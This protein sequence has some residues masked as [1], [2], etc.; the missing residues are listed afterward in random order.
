MSY[1]PFFTLK[2][3]KTSNIASFSSTTDETYIL[4]IANDV[5][6]ILENGETV[7]NSGEHAAVIGANVI[8]DT[9]DNHEAFISLR[10][11]NINAV[12]AKFNSQ[13]I[14]FKVDTLFDNDIIP[15]SSN[16]TS[17][18]G[19]ENNR[20]G[21]IYGSNIIAN[22]S[23]LKN[24]NLNDK[25]T[26]DLNETSENRYYKQSY[27]NNDLNTRL[28]NIYNND[29]ITLDNI[30][31]G[32]INKTIKNNY[33]EGTL[34]VD[35][36]I[37][38][39]YNPDSQG[40]HIKYNI[41]VTNTDQ[42]HEGSTN[43]YFTDNRVSNIVI[44]Q[45]EVIK[46]YVDNRLDN[47]IINTDDITSNNEY[48]NNSN[49]ELANSNLHIINNLN[50][51]YTDSIAT[52]LNSDLIK[53]KTDTQFGFNYFKSDLI[54]TSNIIVNNVNDANTLSLSNISN[55]EIA[56]INEV[57]IITSSNLKFETTVDTLHNYIDT[58]IPII[59][60]LLSQYNFNSIVNSNEIIN[61][62]NLNI[63]NSSNYTSNLNIYTSNLID[64]TS[65]NLFNYSC[66]LDLDTSN[67][68]DITSNNLFND[69]YNLDLDTSNLIDITSNN[70][71]NY[72]SNLNVNISN[73]L[74]ENE[75]Y[76]L[77]TSNH[78][79]NLDTNISNYLF[80]N[81]LDILQTSNNIGTLDIN[82]SNYFINNEAEIVRSSNLTSNLNV[83]ISNYLFKN[84]LDIL[85]TSN[86]IGTLD[87][88]ISNYLIENEAE[89]IRS[90]NLITNLNV[91]ISNYLIENELDILQTS[92]HIGNL[93]TNISNYFINNE[94]EIVRSSNLISNLDVNISNYFIN[95][96]AEIIRSSNLITNLNVNIS[97][98]LIENEAE[99][100]RT[101][102]YIDITS[103]YLYIYTNS[104]D[105]DT[106]NYIYDTS[107]YLEN[108]INDID[109]KITI[110]YKTKINTIGNNFDLIITNLN[111]NFSNYIEYNSNYI[112]KYSC[113]LDLDTSN[114]I[115]ITTNHLFNIID[116]IEYDVNTKLTLIEAINDQTTSIVTQLNIQNLSII[117]NVE[118]TSNHIGN[119]D[120]N[121]SNYLFKNE[122]DILQTSNHIGNLD[123]NISNYLFENE[124]DIL[125]TSNHIGNLD[126]NI[127]NYLFKNELDILQTSNHIGN[128]DTNISNYLFKNELDILQTSN[129]IN[130]LDIK[131][132]HIINDEN[133]LVEF[134]L[135]SSN[136]NISNYINNIESKTSNIEIYSDGNIK[137]NSDLTIDGTLYVNNIDIDGETTIINT[138][139]YQTENLEIINNQGDGPSLKIDHKNQNNNIFE[140]SNLEH[141]III[142]NTGK[143]GINKTP[144]ID[145]DI[146]GSV[147]IDNNLIVNNIAKL[148]N[149][150]IHGDIIPLADDYSIG[151][152]EK[153]WKS[154]YL[155]NTIHLGNL[156]ISTET[157]D[158]TLKTIDNNN[159]G[160][161]VS[162]L[163]VFNDD[164]YRTALTFDG[165]NLEFQG[166]DK[167]GNIINT[168]QKIKGDLSVD[169]ILTLGGG[170]VIHGDLDINNNIIFNGNINNITKTELN[171]LDGTTKNIETNF[172]VTS[173][174]I[175]NLDTNI[176]NYLFKNELDILQTSNHIGNLDANISNYLIEN[177][178]EII[179]SSNL[180][181]NLNVNISNYLF[182]NELDILQTSNHI[183][184]LDT[185]ISNY[186]FK[187]ELDILQTSNHI[188]NLDTNIS[189]YLFKNE[190]DILQT[191]N[192]IGNLD[193]NISNYL[194][195]NEAEI[196]R[197][198]NLTSNLN[199]NISNYL[200]E[201][202]AEI[203]RSS[204]LTS[205]LNVNISNYLFKNE[206]DILQTSNYINDLDIKLLNIINNENELVEFKLLSSNN[207]IS[208]YINNIESKTSNIEVLTNGNIKLN[209]D[210]TIDGTLYV[211]NIDIDGETTIINTNTYQTENLE[212]INNQGDGPSLKIDH[213]NQNNNIIELVNNTNTFIIDKNAN[214]GIN[215]VPTVELDIEGNIKFNG[216]INNISA[217]ELN[218]LDGT[219]KNIETNFTV[220]SNHIGNLDI[221][222]SNYLFK[223]EL[224]IL[225][226]SNNIGNLD[227]NLSNY[228]INNEL[229]ILQT[230]NHIGSLDANISNYLF[231]NELDILQTSNHINDL[232]I[233]LLHIINDENELV[234]FKL[235][236][237][238]NNISN[239]INN[240]ESKTSNIESKTSNIEVLTN[241]N[242]KLN[243]DLTIGGTLYVNNI[244]IDGE[245]TII[246]TNTYQTENLEIINNQGDGPSLKIDHKN[247]NNN[248]IELVNNTDTFII[249]KNANVGI[250]KVPTVE[251]DIEGS[252]KFNGNI[253]NISANVLDYLN[254]TESS[255]QDQLNILKN[256]SNINNIRI[257]DLEY[258]SNINSNT[259]VLL[260][261]F[262]NITSNN[263]VDHDNRI[264]SIEEYNN[265][266]NLE[267]LINN[268]VITN[269]I[270]SIIN[271]GN[272]LSWDNINNKLINDIIQYT[273]D[274]VNTILTTNGYLTIDNIP[275]D[276]S[277]LH[278]VD[279]AL[280]VIDSNIISY[281]NEGVNIKI[282]EVNGIKQ[283]NVGEKQDINYITNSVIFNFTYATQTFHIPNDVNEVV[284]YL[285]GAG[286]GGGGYINGGCGGSGGFTSGIIDVS[287]ISKLYIHVGG[288]GE[289]NMYSSYAEAGYQYGGIGGTGSGA[290][291]GKSGIY[292]SSFSNGNEI[293]IAGGGG[294]GGGTNITNKYCN[295]GGG[296]GIEGR[297]GSII[298]HIIPIENTF[299]NAI[300]RGGKY[301]RGGIGGIS[302]INGNNGIRGEGGDA[303]YI[304]GILFSQGGGGAGYWGGG[305]GG[306]DN[307]F[308]IGSGGGGS[309]YIND[310]YVKN[311]ILL[312]ANTVITGD[313]PIN[314]PKSEN[315]YYI[316]GIGKGGINYGGNGGDGLIIL[317]YK[318]ENTSATVTE[319]LN[320]RIPFND[321]SIPN[322]NNIN[323]ISGFLKFENDKWLVTDELDERI[324]FLEKKTLESLDLIDTINII[325]NIDFIQIEN[326]L[327]DIDDIN[328][329]NS[330][331]VDEISAHNSN[332]TKDLNTNINFLNNDIITN[333]LLQDIDN[334]NISNYINNIEFKTSN[335]EVL[336]NGNIKLN[337]D[338]TIDGTLYVNNIDIDGETTII[339]TNTYQTENLEI[340]NN[341]G[342]GP[343][344]KIDHKNENNNIIELVNNTDTFI[345]DKNANVGINKVP[346][347]ELDIEGSIK[348]NGNINNISS[349]E[350]N[351]LAGTTK[352]IETNFAVTSNHIGNLDT[353]ISNYLFKNELYIL[354]T[355]NHITNL[356]TNLSNYL[357][358]NELDI[359]QT[360]NHIGI[361]DA[362]ISNYLF[363]NELYILQT[364]NHIGSLDA[365]ISNYLI[366]NELDILQT[367]NHIGSLDANISNYLI[368]NELYIL[369]TS[370]HIGNL[371][372][373]IS[374]YLIKN[375][376]DILQT[377]NR[378][379][380]LDTNI[381]NYLIL[382]ELDIL[383]TSN[384][385][386][387]LDTNISNYL[388]LNELD[389][390]RTSNHIGNLDTNI[391]NY[392]VE[393]EIDIKRTSNHIGYLD[394]KIEDLELSNKD[395]SNYIDNISNILSTFIT[396]NTLND[397]TRSNIFVN[398]NIIITTYVNN[399]AGDIIDLIQFNNDN[400]INYI[401]NIDIKV[402]T[403]IDST[404]NNLI[405][406][407][408][409]GSFGGDENNVS[410]Y[411][412]YT[413][414][415]I[416]EYINISSNNQNIRLDTLEENLED[417]LNSN[418]S[419][420]NLIDL[421]IIN[422]NLDSVS[423]GLKNQFIVNNEYDYSLRVKGTLNADNTILNNN[424][425]I[426]NSS[427]YNSGCV[428]IV[429]YGINHAI[430]IEQIGDGDILKVENN[431]IDILKI[432]SN[433]YIGNKNDI[434]YNID[435]DGYI[436]AT[437]LRGDG[438]MINNINLSD[439][440][441]AHLVEGSN[442]YYT[443]ERLY[444]FYQNSNLL[445]SNA[446]FT[447]ILENVQEIKHVMGLHQ[448]DRVEQGTS[449][450][451]IVNNIYNDDLIV[452]GHITA[453]SINILEL[454]TEYYTDLYYSNLFINPFHDERDTFANISNILRNVIIDEPTIGNN[455]NL[456]NRITDII[457][458][459]M[460]N[461]M[462]Q[463]NKIFNDRINNLTLDD[464][465]QG[466]I[467]KY[468]ISNIF[469]ENL[470]VNGNIITKLIDINIEDELFENYSNIY[471]HGLSN[472]IAGNSEYLENRIDSIVDNNMSNYY[473]LIDLHVDNKIKT[474][475]LDN[476]IQGDINKFIIK[477]IYNDDLIVNGEITTKNVD[478]ALDNNLST[479][480][481]NL[482]INEIIN[483]NIAESEYLSTRIT[484]GVNNNISNY[485]VTFNNELDNIN[486]NISNYIIK[487][488]NE[489]L[490]RIDNLTLDN[491]YQGAKNKYIVNDIYNNNL[492]VNGN[493]ITKLIDINIENE[494]FENYSNIY[495]ETLLNSNVDTNDTS[496][497]LY[498]NYIKLSKHVTN[499]TT[500]INNNINDI[501]NIITQYHPDE[502]SSNVQIQEI[503]SLNTK[504]DNL[505]NK[506]S[507]IE[508]ILLN[509]G[510]DITEL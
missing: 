164:G 193:I 71:F 357:I 397:I 369:Q 99:I 61:Y 350:L 287:N 24:V 176:S 272:G 465:Q 69:L 171:Y 431:Y 271:N 501:Y 441:T 340:I 220:T 14:L 351:Y 292:I 146:N 444:D 238:N 75:L 17:N 202:E 84:E 152:I 192:H 157:G 206:L 264:K 276:T 10:N 469:N 112:T 464:I 39:N 133:E 482:Y 310:I 131:L 325:S 191:S 27:F 461:Y 453:K 105:S 286:G 395:T 261:N 13:N 497:T 59:N 312:S 12:V 468:I 417:L 496:I 335:I 356:D 246:N 140:A 378:I 457:D 363:K 96:E 118:N 160:I 43:L 134:K 52:A 394:S 54:H 339:N 115:D 326:V 462:D 372:T 2:G 89:I 227:T 122:L 506:Y 236:S 342:D 329:N 226:T 81:E 476:I 400:T 283:L 375:E 500:L 204:N 455:S 22:G 63:I 49:Y 266:I 94:V 430:K 374:N 280:K 487:I 88:N 180:T 50:L 5:N 383:Q 159:A 415:E 442:L 336:T 224:Y 309:G 219:T 305:S 113:N 491:I 1:N 382:N 291:G 253:N 420:S 74:I 439:K 35:D 231:K 239:Y 40:F 459:G 352:H 284:A 391:S 330:N 460:L 4:L 360:S 144:T 478:I 189:N 499:Q 306:L 265:T 449:N 91:N 120:T 85:Q 474:I 198:S 128:L 488:N 302:D 33:Y 162:E 384:R 117:T 412:L 446:Q 93:D 473:S 95:N 173:N 399:T 494:L 60:S 125:Q 129:H 404:S 215:K 466:N 242:I 186:L 142:D 333:K 194:I 65:N 44:N 126:T 237:S 257:N 155:D 259:I 445:L 165:N 102:N 62:I 318:I 15:S 55:F 234:E 98:Y 80:K 211:N 205:N 213:K 90:S 199:V 409:N 177:E 313:I 353:N 410:N 230:S 448:L 427:I 136:N 106:S 483:H 381:S 148:S 76:I 321:L 243:S 221:N 138:N 405:E 47:I 141:F 161:N 480:Y 269:T 110:D 509:L 251:L 11:D 278:I 268:E 413:S 245:T 505:T 293:L 380:N 182:K 23:F 493:I 29:L 388:I 109:N 77:Q 73:Y 396:S 364:S 203:I 450:K 240:I 258:N 492:V 21:N 472:A 277:T 260:E 127:S 147:L 398:S 297:N 332:Y 437:N 170:Y 241:G 440:S 119:L 307:T 218:Y 361:L 168:T 432:T 178:E 301:N 275:L 244:D 315:E 87:I 132:L 188:G 416:I 377:S 114:Y 463:I 346:T 467:N 341:Q 479:L 26:N 53:L 92:N 403:S 288:G 78:I 7:T 294:G 70:L 121:I 149:I 36:I 64:I 484:D 209:S 408:N 282:N 458:Y 319:N 379:G 424:A 57:D 34:V 428:N 421:D 175:G 423:Q 130:D 56:I 414:N 502:M 503:N 371:D 300:G 317:I 270:P 426:V 137:L 475:S 296:G 343:S 334:H 107:N 311:S 103:N 456:E 486:N 139:T 406:Y 299:T 255:I 195:E 67:L 435:I 210:L 254:G 3:G 252:I 200:I 197:S 422:I 267:Q 298:E 370:N 419:I 304:N 490:N 349:T 163:N 322:N 385:I 248:I 348:F 337:S 222:I 367:S 436:N 504:L 290:G 447:E 233:K 32:T 46:N 452:L 324:N 389:I 262:S 16:I 181:S 232:D 225:Q 6:Q 30:Q 196:I 86:H 250:N 355:S 58:E 235:L 174:H 101:S 345:I 407:I 485:T 402:E 8:D 344:L 256:S 354:Q 285:W 214:V 154:I 470:I 143:L 328:R 289:G 124:L 434:T 229:D 82:I 83:N 387:N 25:T 68:I 320:Y 208:N 104:L 386:R 508:N 185:N 19:S 392:L 228:L 20:W 279:G 28:L 9:S 51:I 201:N 263:I 179:R 217:T 187:N 314:P 108:Y 481:S 438:S 116:T 495:N 411:V 338:L 273:D 249:D 167:N 471:N 376:L 41:N 72:S 365:N 366:N 362:N 358:N 507:K 145:L 38:N 66:N 510:Y 158:M 216:N 166:Y 295:G 207:N 281:E 169:G 303:E 153:N 223:N 433:G 184:N 172:T 190:L 48:L 401:N 418:L 135:L 123:T 373:N 247:Q 45:Q 331:Y 368:L 327:N 323:L 347:V 100:I 316:N 151:T 390:L 183:G 489:I 498:E 443:E 31:Q 393:N 111:K 429:N 425:T 308:G 42:I 454:D 18:I 359:L 477:N 212:I 274:N 97:N 37:I 156:L 150:E 79:G 451:Y